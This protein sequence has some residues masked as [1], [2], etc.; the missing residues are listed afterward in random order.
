MKII[1][2]FG[3]LP[4]FKRA[5]LNTNFIQHVVIP[6]LFNES[7]IGKILS[8]W[9]DS[10]AK[11]S[12]IVSGGKGVVDY[13]KRKS[14]V[15][16]IYPEENGWIYDK[17]AMACILT[18]ASK[19]QFDITGFQT[20]LQ[21]ANYGPGG[22]FGWHMDFGPNKNSLRKLSITVQLSNPDEY[23]GGD[24]QFLNGNNVVSMS[25]EIGTAIIFPSFIAHRVEPVI[26]GSRKS[27]V[28]WIAGP[29]YR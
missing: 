13:E 21:L 18:N 24:F 6:N 14:E 25:K 4:E 26:S 22:F 29:P 12:R 7:E 20:H 2:P 1:R 28:G 15:I 19:Y 10:I 16:F 9:D 5:E 27:I 8:L 17:L 11:D 3:Q 23:E